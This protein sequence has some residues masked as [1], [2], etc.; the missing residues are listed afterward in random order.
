MENQE[1]SG[2]GAI[3]GSVIIIVVILIGGWY[4]ISNRIAKIEEQKQMAPVIEESEFSTST[5]MSDIEADLGKIDMKVLDQ[6]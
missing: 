2:P 6:Q 3:I 5:E 4:F 1:K